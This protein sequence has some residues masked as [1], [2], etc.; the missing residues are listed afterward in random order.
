MLTCTEFGKLATEYNVYRILLEMV[1]FEIDIGSL[2]GTF[3]TACWKNAYF[4][5]Q[6]LPMI[7]RPGF[8]TIHD[9]LAR[10]SLTRHYSY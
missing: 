6:A 10:H 4:E 3:K 7:H 8:H 2:I 5:K 1:V 9:I